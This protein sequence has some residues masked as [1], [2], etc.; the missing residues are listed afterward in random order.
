[1]WSNVFKFILEK[2]T[3]LAAFIVVIGITIW[4]S[5]KYFKTIG[6]IK[7]TE[8]QCNECNTKVF[9]D[10][11]THFGNI[12]NTL[13]GI[14]MSLV[15]LSV[16][17]KS[18][19]PGIDTSLFIARSPIQLSHLGISILNDIGGKKIL[20][21]NYNMFLSELE[22]QTFKTGLD[23]HVFCINM[24]M[25][26]FNNDIFIPVKDYLFNNPNYKFKNKEGKEMEYHLDINDI[27]TILGVYLRDKYFES[28]PDLLQLWENPLS[29]K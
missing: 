12:D 20:D 3:I 27:F 10:L 26:M 13:N 25:N 2:S 19:D 1:M 9:P 21:E 8:D 4:V 17:L 16:Y 22:K 11:N 23:A 7:K 14:R 5:R 24:I 18:N 28:H 6:R 15:A 29:A